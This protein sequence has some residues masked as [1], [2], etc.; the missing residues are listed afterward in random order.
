MGVQ[1]DTVIFAK[2][3][4]YFPQYRIDAVADGL[5]TALREAQGGKRSWFSGASFSH[6]LVSSVVGRSQASVGDLVRRVA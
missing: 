3:W 2:T 4:R 6:E 1:V 5:F